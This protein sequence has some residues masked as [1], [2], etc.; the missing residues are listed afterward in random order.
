MLQQSIKLVPFLSVSHLSPLPQLGFR[1]RRP[2]EH[3]AAPTLAAPSLPYL[4][5]FSV[6]EP[7]RSRPRHHRSPLMTSFDLPSPRSLSPPVLHLIAFFPSRCRCCLP[8]A[9]L[10]IEAGVVVVQPRIISISANLFL[11]ALFSQILNI[12]ISLLQSNL[13]ICL[14]LSISN[15]KDHISLLLLHNE[16]PISSPSISRPKL[17]PQPAVS[18][19]PPRGR[20]FPSISVE[21]SHCRVEA[22]FVTG[23]AVANTEPAPHCF[24]LRLSI[25]RRPVRTDL[26]D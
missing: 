11:I 9:S 2:V 6:T 17:A 13:E 15:S 24:C 4:S 1:R 16:T 19:A 12:N 8:V 14:S 21:H 3:T 20:P 7:L 22:I 25:P 5:L 18:A 26:G 23:V 10:L